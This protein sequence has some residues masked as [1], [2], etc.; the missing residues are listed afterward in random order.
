MV[1]RMNRK[2]NGRLFK[3]SDILFTVLAGI[4]RAG[5]LSHHMYQGIAAKMLGRDN[6]PDH[7]VIRRRIDSMD[8]LGDGA[9]VHPLQN[10]HAVPD[11]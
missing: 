11:P 3:Y 5:D 6:A 1:T 10:R 7:A 4:R 8:I 2:K 9:C